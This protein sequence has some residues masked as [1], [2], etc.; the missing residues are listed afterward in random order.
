MGPARKP[1]RPRSAGAAEEETE[2]KSGMNL[3]A[4]KGLNWPTVILILLT[5]GGNFLAL[6]DRRGAR[7][8]SIHPLADS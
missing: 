3:E 4:L 1:R 7:R 8:H 6:G 2:A 5:G